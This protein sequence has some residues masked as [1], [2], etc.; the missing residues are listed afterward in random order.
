[1]PNIVLEA[2]AAPRSIFPNPR[3]FE[4]LLA[5]IFLPEKIP[6]PLE[7]P[8]V[9]IPIPFPNGLVLLLEKEKLLKK[10]FFSSFGYS[11]M[12]PSLTFS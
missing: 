4:S 2:L 11:F 8:L 7:D 5:K 1:M 10:F 3:G 12:S 6:S 9:K